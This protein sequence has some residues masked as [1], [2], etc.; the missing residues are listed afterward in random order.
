M[1]GK[2]STHITGFNDKL[3]SQLNLDE[4]DNI[5]FHKF[6]N[7]TYA[8]IDDGENKKLVQYTD[9]NKLNI[10]A[11]KLNDIN[12][13]EFGKYIS[14]YNK[15]GDIIVLDKNGN[16]Y[17]E[18]NVFKY[19]SNNDTAIELGVTIWGKNND[20]LYILTKKGDNLSNIFEV[21]M[22]DKSIKD[23]AFDIDCRYENLYIDILEGYVVYSTF[24]GPI[25]YS[26][27]KEVNDDVFIYVK[28]LSTGEKTEIARVKGASILFYIFNNEL[29]LYCRENDDI[30]GTYNLIGDVPV[31]LSQEQEDTSPDQQ[32]LLNGI[33]LTKDI[34]YSVYRGEE[35]YRYEVLL[36]ALAINDDENNLYKGYF[37]FDEN[38]GGF[39]FPLNKSNEVMIQVFGEKEYPSF[40]EVFD[41]DKESDTYYKNLDFGWNTAYR[42]ENVTAE[43]SDDKLKLYTQFQLINQWYDVGGDPVPTAIAECKI[44]YSIISS[45]DRTYLQF[46]NMEIVNK[47]VN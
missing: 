26:Y 20:I 41:Y 29:E 28:Y 40:E 27:D 38:K 42:A 44:T 7:S 14:L 8:V 13:S 19:I 6:N 23:L 35:N 30:K 21:N 9:D 11:D 2:D 43:I 10:I 24:P 16:K 3:Y 46:K 5:N 47:L 37:P 18:D 33:S 32:L 15:N 17:L 22:I 45:N 25:F 1:I 31:S 36:F 39:T 4:A 12:F 34:I